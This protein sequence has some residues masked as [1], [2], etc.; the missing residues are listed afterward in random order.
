MQL[1]LRTIVFMTAAAASHAQAD[2]IVSL[3]RTGDVLKSSTF[4]VHPGEVFSVDA[5]ITSTEVLGDDLNAYLAEFVSTPLGAS[6]ALF[7]DQVALPAYRSAPAHY[8]FGDD[9]VVGG[10]I[11]TPFLALFDGAL[12]FPTTSAVTST[13]L[14]LARMELVADPLG[15][16]GDSILI[17]LDTSPASST[18][19]FGA[20]SLIDIDSVSPATITIAAVP[21]PSTFLVA[22]LLASGAGI[23]W[24]RRRRSI[25]AATNTSAG[26]SA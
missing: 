13:P 10:V 1:Y 9:E 3:F 26:G 11:P 5:E 6:T 12:A 22:G 24:K 8:V 19:F 7:T 21:E 23:R 20:A 15:A 2:I 16:P 25:H 18:D 4:S 14:L 17:D